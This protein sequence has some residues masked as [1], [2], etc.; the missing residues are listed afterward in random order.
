MD[1]EIKSIE[2]QGVSAQKNASPLLV[3]RTPK[4][5]NT[6]KKNPATAIGLSQNLANAENEHHLPKN[7]SKTKKK[8]KILTQKK[9][10]SIYIQRENEEDFGFVKNKVEIVNKNQNLKKSIYEEKEN[11]LKK[12]PRQARCPKEEKF[13][14]KEVS[15]RTNSKITF[16]TTES[17]FIDNTNKNLMKSG[18]N[19]TIHQDEVRKDREKNENLVF[20]SNINNIFKE[21]GITLNNVDKKNLHRDKNIMNNLN[22][23]SIIQKNLAELALRKKEYL[24][25][26]FMQKSFSLDSNV[27]NEFKKIGRIRT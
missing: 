20:D 14:L 25:E 8:S 26:I 23:L 7:F 12:I 15:N 5:Y 9:S 24:A 27:N 18:Y 13:L 21:L 19:Q 3:K 17:I 16:P 4:F 1:V 6:L 22:I 11:T 2:K 10:K